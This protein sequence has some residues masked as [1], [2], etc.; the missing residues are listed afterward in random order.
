MLLIQSQLREALAVALNTL[1]P[2][3]VPAAQF[4]SP[5]V[6]AHGDLACTAALQRNATSA[7]NTASTA[8]PTSIIGESLEDNGND[9]QRTQ[10]VLSA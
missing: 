1:A 7:A 8:D 6:A 4:E 3:Q 5:K 10:C 2:G 9:V